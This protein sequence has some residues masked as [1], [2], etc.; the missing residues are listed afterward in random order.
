MTAA[1]RACIQAWMMVIAWM[2]LIFGLSAQPQ[3]PNLGLGP[4]D[5]QDILG[6]FLVY[7]GLAFW[8]ACAAAYAHRAPASGLDA[9][10]GDAVRAE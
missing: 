1:R 3:L 8:L 4:A 6:H 10:P 2:A 7:A 9:G 5:L